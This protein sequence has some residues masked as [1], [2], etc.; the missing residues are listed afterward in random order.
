MAVTEQ[1]ALVSRMVEGSRELGSHSSGGEVAA[2]QYKV[3]DLRSRYTRIAEESDQKIELLTEAIPLSEEYCGA[4][5]NLQDYLDAIS[6][7]KSLH[8]RV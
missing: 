5:D 8:S 2:L 4:V 3:E 6:D 7:G 1:E